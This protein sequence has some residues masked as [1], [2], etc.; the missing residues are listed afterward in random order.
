MFLCTV[1]KYQVKLDDG[2]IVATTPEDGVEFHVKDG[3]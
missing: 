1:V 3:T 2:A